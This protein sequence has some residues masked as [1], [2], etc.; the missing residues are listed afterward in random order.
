[1]APFCGAPLRVVEGAGC[2]VSFDA[3]ETWTR[4]V[5]SPSVP[6]RRQTHQLKLETVQRLWSCEWPARVVL[7]QSLPHPKSG[8]GQ[9][10]GDDKPKRAQRGRQVPVTSL[11]FGGG[12]VIIIAGPYADLRAWENNTAAPRIAVSGVETP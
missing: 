8:L 4:R 11:P 6:P 7:L 10:N 1:M 3:L 9:R 5:A 12:S 2:F